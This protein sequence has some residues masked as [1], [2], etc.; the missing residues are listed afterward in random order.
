MDSWNMSAAAVGVA[1]DSQGWLERL[2]GS[3]ADR[4]AALVELH[5]LLL[6][7]ARFEVNRRRATSPHLRGSDYDDLAQQSADDALVGILRKLGDFRGDSRFTT[8]A[9]KFALYE[10]AANVRKRAWQGRE[11]PLK[12]EAWPLIVD[13]HQHSAQQSVE[14]NDVLAVLG[15]AIDGELSPHQREVL[16]AITLNGV[17][18]DVLADRLSTTRGALYKTLHDARHKLRTALAAQGI[19][20]D[21]DPTRERT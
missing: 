1:Q 4:D 15:E 21:Q 13:D 12:A 19:G 6:R 20:L 5:A 2:Q 17:P 11:I 18:I 8:W 7:A 16:V 9:Y 3:G 10:A 14:T